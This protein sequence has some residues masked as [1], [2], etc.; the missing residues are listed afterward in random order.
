M[1]A[2]GSVCIWPCL[3]ALTRGRSARMCLC[4]EAELATATL[5]ALC[6]SAHLRYPGNGEPDTLQH[7]EAALHHH[8]GG[9]HPHGQA[10]TATH[11]TTVASRC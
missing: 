7:R 11:S 10:C 5:G 4:C 3:D 9:A 6:V 1:Q 8:E 2:E